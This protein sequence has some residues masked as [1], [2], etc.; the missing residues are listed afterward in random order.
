MIHLGEPEEVARSGKTPAGDRRLILS[1]SPSGADVQ[2]R[3]A[4]PARSFTPGE[5]AGG[6][7]HS[8][9]ARMKGRRQSRESRQILPRALTPS[10]GPDRGSPGGHRQ[11]EPARGPE[12]RSIEPTESIRA[13]AVPGAGPGRPAAGLPQAR[14]RGFR[15][16]A[17]GAGSRGGR[18]EP[19]AARPV[20]PFHETNRA[21]D[22]KAGAG[23]SPFLRSMFPMIKRQS[24]WMD[25]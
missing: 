12:K 3:P 21:P 6:E 4:A 5:F 20:V 15:I 7:D 19:F 13:S 25:N 14:R 11:C 18:G 24:N 16:A 22:Q 17:G 10:S 9:R 2:V 8:S 1:G 23:R